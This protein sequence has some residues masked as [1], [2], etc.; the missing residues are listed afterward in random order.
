VSKS[1]FEFVTAAACHDKKVGNC[2]EVAT[3][4]PGVVALREGENPG[5]VV[6]TT[7]ERWKVFITAAKNGEFD[8]TA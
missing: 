7:P 5:T 3:N 1:K 6:L 8:T 2:V 4:V